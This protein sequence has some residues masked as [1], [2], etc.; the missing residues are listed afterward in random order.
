MGTFNINITATGGH[1]CDRKAKTGEKLYGRCGKFSCPDCMAYNFIQ[2]MK[3]A[4]FFS[5]EPNPQAL[6]THWP[7]DPEHM[8]VDDMLFNQRQS[9]QF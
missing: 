2:Q 4:G 3:Q 1:G 8:V 9:G 6:F 5:S 7:N